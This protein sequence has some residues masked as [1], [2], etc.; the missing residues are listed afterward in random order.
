MWLLPGSG[1]FHKQKS[2]Q[3]LETKT[4]IIFF[5]LKIGT[6]QKLFLGN[7]KQLWVPT[8]MHVWFLNEN[9]Y[10]FAKLIEHKIKSENLASNQ[11]LL[12]CP[13]NVCLT[14]RII[15]TMIITFPCCLFFL[16]LW[17]WNLEIFLFWKKEALYCNI[18]ASL[19]FSNFF[20]NLLVNCSIITL[21]FRNISNFDNLQKLENKNSY[22]E[23][24]NSFGKKGCNCKI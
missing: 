16:K 2:S 19:Y 4:R 3:V 7:W 1:I 14:I 18:I 8:V 22:N 10:C 24:L 6:G 17:N 13:E 23:P 5:W 15:T 11:K 21:R 9:R 12:W 20:W